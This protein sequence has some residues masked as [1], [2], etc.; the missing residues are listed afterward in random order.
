LKSDDERTL[1]LPNFLTAVACFCFPASLYFGFARG[2]NDPG[3]S[4]LLVM[5]GLGLIAID[6]R[7]YNIGR[8]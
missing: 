7:L 2:G 1:W 4:M 3:S 6:V 8:R 5:L